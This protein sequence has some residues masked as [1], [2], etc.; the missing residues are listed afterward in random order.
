MKQELVELGL[1]LGSSDNALHREQG[2]LHRPSGMLY[3]GGDAYL[4]YK[5]P[6]FLEQAPGLP[7][8]ETQAVR[9]RVCSERQPGLLAIP[10]VAPGVQRFISGS[11]D[12]QSFPYRA[13]V[14]RAAP[15]ADGC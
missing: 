5:G 14:V 2:A 4:L 9:L 13:R 3:V 10:G 7:G 8:D 1:A 12:S 11:L 6:K 15:A